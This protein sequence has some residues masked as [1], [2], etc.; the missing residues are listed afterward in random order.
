M[1]GGVIT[2]RSWYSLSDARIE[3]SFGPETGRKSEGMLG[4]VI[5]CWSWYSLSDSRIED[6]LEDSCSIEA[7]PKHMRV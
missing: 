7:L 3:G 2:C 5:T 6:F 1:L 4:G